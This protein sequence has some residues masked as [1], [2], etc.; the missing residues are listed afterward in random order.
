MIELGSK[1]H[2]P[3]KI[4]SHDHINVLYAGSVRLVDTDGWNF[5]KRLICFEDGKQ[6]LEHLDSYRSY[7]E[8]FTLLD[9]GAFSAWTK[10]KTI[11]LD[12][13][14]N[15]I[16][17]YS[18]VIN[19]AANLDVIPGRKGQREISD[20]EN[21][22]AASMGWMNYF[23]LISRLRAKG[24]EDLC[25]R[26][27]PIH[28]QGESIDILKRM[29]DYGC[30]YI[31]V[32]PSNDARTSQRIK[33][34]DQAFGYLSTQPNRILTHGYAVTSEVLM[35]SF[36]WFTVDSITWIYIA[37]FGIVKTPF[38]QF[39]FSEDPRSL[40]NKDNLRIVLEEDGDWK[41][42]NAHYSEY[43]EIISDYVKNVLFMDVNSLSQD[44]YYRALANMIYFQNFEKTCT[45]KKRKSFEVSVGDFSAPEDI[46]PN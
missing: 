36:P 41:I 9:S 3:K 23:E 8:I 28:H 42:Q 13:Y 27:M 44:Y 45:G 7:P 33:Y 29:V 38:G 21:I 15:V 34:L 18:D 1:L 6:T 32:S 30:T 24:R 40:K 19:M 4:L 39:C 31:G 2:D 12:E 26:V 11:D 25:S 10:G 17:E 37:G 46:F 20:G 5:K 22:R 35:D 16:I 43:R 14:A